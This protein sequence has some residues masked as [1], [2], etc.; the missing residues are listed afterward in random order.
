MNENTRTAMQHHPIPK[1]ESKEDYEDAE[2]G[3]IFARVL[4]GT[5]GSRKIAWEDICGWQPANDQETLWLHM[6]REI[7]PVDDWLI[8]EM[9]ISDTTV[10]L[11]ISDETRP[12]AF[13]E[14]DALVT[15]LR[16]INLNPGAE[17]EDMVA[18]HIWSDGKRLV[19]L[20]R[21]RLQTPR[22]VLTMLKRKQGPKN[23]GDLLTELTEQ[24]VSKIN[25]S[26]VEMN[27]HIDQLEACPT[28]ERDVDAML[29]DIA[30]IRRNCLALKRFMSPQHE[31]L[32]QISRIA[33]DWISADNKRDIR[34]TIDQLRR[35]LED[36]DVSKESA[37]VL[38]DD[39]NNRAA[40]DANH[41][42][43]M[44][45]I[46]AAVFLPLS[47]VTGLLGINVGGMPGVDNGDAFW[48]TIIVL[49]LLCAL[50]IWIFK[51]LKW[52]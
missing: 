29:D 14:D 30:D 34:E 18:L 24:L 19:S 35:Y 1:A 32:L 12:R 21:R 4:T 22:D 25:V 10:D 43:Y 11:L 20:R 36:L 47:F 27:N 15:I 41:T 8:A 3:I 31:A 2:N 5:G 13:R 45:S 23:A 51:K 38:Q 17:P 44:L 46:V 42:M 39:I 6:D 40:A 16:G 9:G 28:D 49:T 48:I 26:I 50:Q 33:P 37:L 52:L 7:D